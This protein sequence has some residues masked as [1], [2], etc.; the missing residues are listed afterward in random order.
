MP[1]NLE[2]CIALVREADHDRYLATLFASAQHRD[3]L[4]ALYA[5]NVEIARVRDLARQPM[6]GEIRLQWWRE[7]L[8]GE[9]A[10]EAAANPVAAAL[11]GTMAHYGIAADRLIELIDAHAF[12]LYDEPMA[13]LDDLDDYA[14]GTQATLL[15]IAAEILA[16]RKEPAEALIRHAG[17]AYAITS[18]LSL[19]GRHAARRQLYLP[20]EVLDRHKATPADI[21]ALEGGAPLLAALAELRRHARRQLA[22]A[23]AELA[24]APAEILPALLPVAL[25]GPTL[26]RME[27]RGYEPFQFMPPSRLSRQWTLWRA[28][29]KPSRIFK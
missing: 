16:G 11:S 4:Y 19:L 15:Q 20:L 12:D 17:S 5:F 10:S 1:S 29:K 6:P 14:R 25:V 2:H 28:A 3:A 18:I 27:W 7:A 21:F 9:R 23:S 22:A 26:R 13:S 24:S 8:L